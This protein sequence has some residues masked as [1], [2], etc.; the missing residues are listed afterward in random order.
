MAALL[1]VDDLQVEFRTR[2][3]TALVLNGVE[4][5]LNSG[6]TLCVVGESGCG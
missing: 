3:G 2:R 6:E 1:K 5:E 4:F